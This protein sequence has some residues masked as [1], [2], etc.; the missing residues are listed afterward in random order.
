MLDRQPASVTYTNLNFS[1]F[2]YM[3][4]YCPFNYIHYGPDSK[5]QVLDL[6]C[7]LWRAWSRAELSKY[8]L[9]VEELK[10]LSFTVP[11]Y[12]HASF[13]WVP[14]VHLQMMPSW[15]KGYQELCVAIFSS[16]AG[17]AHM[18][19]YTPGR[20]WDTCF[21]KARLLWDLCKY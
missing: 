11:P 1:L 14:L 2:F 4:L 15:K 16:L 9:I 21:D 17:H 7:I 20:H 3:H 10:T 18:P 12:F 19:N 6:F 5:N 13:P 8:L